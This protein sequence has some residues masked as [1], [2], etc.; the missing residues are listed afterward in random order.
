MPPGGEPS[1]LLL[2][3]GA[4]ALQGETGRAERVEAG[5][6]GQG[7]FRARPDRVATLRTGRVLLPQPPVTWAASRL[8]GVPGLAP[9]S[10]ATVAT[11][12]DAPSL[13][14]HVCTK[15]IPPRDKRLSPPPVPSLC[16][17]RPR[18]RGHHAPGIPDLSFPTGAS[19]AETRSSGLGLL[20]AMVQRGP[21]VGDVSDLRS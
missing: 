16:S 19:M 3:V 6:Q 14:F 17:H 13:S 15:R 10:C 21:R 5:S 9:T 18:H 20:L 4:A 8:L 2:N 1:A 11:P 7:A 12:L